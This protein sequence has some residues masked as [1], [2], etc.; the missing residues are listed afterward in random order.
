MTR[1][2]AFKNI[3]FICDVLLG[4]VYISWLTLNITYMDTLQLQTPPLQL[5][6]QNHTQR[7]CVLDKPFDYEKV[8]TLNCPKF[9][10]LNKSVECVYPEMK[11]EGLNVFN[12]RVK[13][14]RDLIMNVIV[15]IKDVKQRYES[16]VIKLTIYLKIFCFFLLS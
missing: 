1:S 2:N 14:M 8:I 16:I 13:S 15:C 7:T 6:K 12:E 4:C 11:K 5:K 9:I 3:E 10:G